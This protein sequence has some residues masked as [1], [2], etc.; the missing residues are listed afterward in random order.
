MAVALQVPAV[1]IDH[2]VTFAR[3]DPDSTQMPLGIELSAGWAAM[4]SLAEIVGEV[5][6]NLDFLS[7]DLRDLPARHRSM[8]AVFDASWQHLDPIDR[9][10]FSQVSVFRGGFTRQAAE[11]AGASLRHLGHL[12]HKSLLH[13]DQTRNRYW[14]HELLHQYGATKLAEDSTAASTALTRHCDYFVTRL[15]A[16]WDR[17]RGARPLSGWLMPTRSTNPELR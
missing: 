12:I 2:V 1:Q 6:R 4:M 13:Y 15:I 11:I 3:L 8:R 5:Q 9:S 16:C 17:L 7:S 14:L 10:I